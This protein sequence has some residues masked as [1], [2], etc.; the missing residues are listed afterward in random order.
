MLSK[1][2]S[3]LYKASARSHS[4]LIWSIGWLCP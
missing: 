4:I 3:N 1:Q 2:I